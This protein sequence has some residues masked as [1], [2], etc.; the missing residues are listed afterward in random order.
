MRAVSLIEPLEDRI[1]PAGGLT[2]APDHKS[3][4]YTD[5]FGDTVVVTTTKGAFAASQFV[6]DPNSPGQLMELNLSGQHQFNGANLSFSL[7]PVAG[8][9]S[10]VN[11]GYIDALGVNLG[12]VTVPGDLGRIDAG[13]GTASLALGKLT[14][15]TLGAEGNTTQGGGNGTFVASTQSNITG[16]VGMINV[17]GNVYGSIFAQDYKGKVGTGNIAQLNIGGSLDGNTGVGTGDI[18][19]TGTLG[20]AVI[21]GGIE[22]GP[23]N[24]SGSIGGYDSASGGGYGTLSK[25]G[26][27]TVKGSVPDD[28]NPNPIPTLPGTSIL[29]GTGGLSGSI[30]AVTVG[31]VYVAG[32]VH[33]GTG[34]ASGSIQGG[35]SLGK[36]TIAGS[37]I[38]GNFTPG[39]STEANSSGIVFGGTIESVTIGHVIGKKIYG[40]NISGGSGSSS[41]EVYSTGLIGKVTVMG[42]LAGGSAGTASTGGFSGGINAQVLG[43]VVVDGSVIGGN[44]VND[45]SSDQLGSLDGVIISNSTIGSVF[46]AK[47]L[48]GGGG[49]NS[50]EIATGTGVNSGIGSVTI[51]ENIVGGSGLQSGEVN[52]DGLIQKVTVMGNVIGGTAGVAATSSAAAI[53]G[54]AGSIDAMALGS[55]VIGGSVIGGNLVAGD[56]NQT[57][58]TDGV[59]VSNTTIGSLSIAKN[60]IGGSGPTSGAI[61]TDNSGGVGTLTI[62]K[63]DKT[64]G[65]NFDSSVLGGS[66]AASGTI[67][68]AGTVGTLLLTHDLTGGSGA[69]STTIL[70]SGSISVNGPVNSLVIGGSI[71]GG[72]ADDTGTISVFG[73]LK[74][75]TIKNNI[76]GSNSA[77][78]LLSDTGYVQADGIGTMT[79]GGALTAGQT[80]GPGTLDTSGA[81]RSTVA[82]GSITVGSLV[83]NATNPAI[84][85]AVGPANLAASAKTDVAIQN[86]TVHGNATYG[87]ILA[88]YNTETNGGMTPTGTGVNADA[89]IGT[90]SI[91]GNLEATNIIAGVGPGTTGFG[92]AGSAA[93]SGAGVTDVPSIISTIS[94]IIITGNVVAP[95]TSTTDTYG[96]AAQYIANAKVAGQQLALI[97][98]PDNDT[99]PF[100]DK[101][102][103]TGGNADVFL[104]EV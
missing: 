52:S 84:I 92:T 57:G 30:A 40:G 33:G 81:I 96:I 42:N 65:S 47:N 13:G 73:L 62:G 89:Q 35:T 79:V 103:L 78:A 60:L 67:L 5:P 102:L 53:T 87:D 46:V 49:P 98:G 29:G 41:G 64:T 1:A 94:R 18:F 21:G 36:V 8:G 2:I 22:G 90:V 10:N 68:V 50:G 99:F 95:A 37:L 17:A 59:I 97:A 54:T 45:G 66:G 83:G 93:L 86:I 91:G 31:S 27:I 44:P 19:F 39:N 76:T 80:S 101:Q 77:T 104:Y 70:G 48:I 75:A 20:K 72:S 23:V 26:S 82:I 61:I 51:G 3:A 32:D 12:S 9:I 11:I 16:T 85:S 55:V 38:G 14:I 56:S 28:P 71:T 69:G 7:I 25:I 43:S 63:G 100:H 88:G 34:V 74:S 15:D 24:F 6:F 4:H 58:D